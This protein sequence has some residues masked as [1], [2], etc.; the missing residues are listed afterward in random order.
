MQE[1][2]HN[3]NGI[4]TG[5]VTGAEAEKERGKVNDSGIRVGQGLHL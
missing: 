1:A 3:R 4:I 5:N 2:Q